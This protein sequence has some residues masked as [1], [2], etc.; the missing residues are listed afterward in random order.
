MEP[1]EFRPKVD[2]EVRFD[3]AMRYP[4]ALLDRNA[5]QERNQAVFEANDA[6][7]WQV[8]KRR[9]AKSVAAAGTKPQI[10]A[11]EEYNSL[12]SANVAG[13]EAEQIR[14]YD[15]KRYFT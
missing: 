8:A 6:V 11:A 1:L 3:V 14:G 7:R 15:S 10:I 2:R 12:K 4:D 9:N 5:R 13:V